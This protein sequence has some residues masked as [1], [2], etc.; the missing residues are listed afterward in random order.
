MSDRV[1]FDSNILI[2]AYSLDD[3]FKRQCVKQLADSHDVIIISTQ[4]INEF[5]NVMFKKKKMS[6]Q[7]I[8]LVL[9]EMRSNFVIETIDKDIIEKAIDIAMRHS[10]SYFDSLM[11][12]SALANGCSILY[13]ED[14]HDQ[15]IIENN[16][17]MIN[18][19]KN[20]F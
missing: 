18:P 20:K 15:H 4:T 16:L 9:N 3:L 11:I 14:M 8:I 2:Y 5:V 6:Y 17:K 10:Y 1:F 19:F 7:Q 12:A 13:T